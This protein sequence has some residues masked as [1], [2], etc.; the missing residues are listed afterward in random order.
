MGV[1]IVPPENHLIKNNFALGDDGIFINYPLTI[2]GCLF[3]EVISLWRLGVQTRGV[4]CG[5][6]VEQGYIQV[7]RTSFGA[8]LELGYVWYQ[9]YPKHLGG[10]DRLDAFIPK[11]KCKCK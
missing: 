7:E 9:A 10:S 3:D 5:H 2:D 1:V 8:M 4:C 11:S 6:F